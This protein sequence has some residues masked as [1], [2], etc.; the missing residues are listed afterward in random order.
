MSEHTYILNRS[1]HEKSVGHGKY[2]LQVTI[3]TSSD[4]STSRFRSHLWGEN[5]EG[6]LLQSKAIWTEASGVTRYIIWGKGTW[7]KETGRPV[8][9]TQRHPCFI[10]FFLPFHPR[11]VY[12]IKDWWGRKNPANDQQF[13]LQCKIKS[14]WWSRWET[15]LQKR[16]QILIHFVFWMY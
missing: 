14:C 13:I 3:K 16:C 12:L 5:S 8:M 11:K 6:N 10:F 4:H 15:D 2:I 1:C 7:C 9:Q